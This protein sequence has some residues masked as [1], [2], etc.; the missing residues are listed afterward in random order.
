MISERE[1]KRRLTMLKTEVNLDFPGL[2]PALENGLQVAAVTESFSEFDLNP[3]G[4]RRLGGMVLLCKHY[5]AAVVFVNEN[6]F[7]EIN[8]KNP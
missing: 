6:K 2:V 1:L 8:S 4:L 7:G 5:G 3:D